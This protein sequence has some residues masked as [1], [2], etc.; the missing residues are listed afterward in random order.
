[1][2]YSLGQKWDTTINTRFCLHVIIHFGIDVVEPSLLKTFVHA[3]HF[4]C[5]YYDKKKNIF[6]LDIIF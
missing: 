3:S 4:L 6:K 5:K 2:V 1:M